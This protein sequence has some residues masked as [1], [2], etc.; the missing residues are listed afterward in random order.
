MAPEGSPDGLAA[1]VPVTPPGPADRGAQPPTANDAT[2]A[3][4]TI[5]VVIEAVSQETRIRGD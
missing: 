3:A 5:E 1:Q 2:A 4:A